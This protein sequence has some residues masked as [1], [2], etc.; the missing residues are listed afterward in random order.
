MEEGPGP[1]GEPGAAAFPEQE[2]PGDFSRQASSFQSY[3]SGPSRQSS[4][5]TMP[6]NTLLPTTSPR[7]LQSF[8]RMWPEQPSAQAMH[9]SSTAASSAGP[10]QP[11]ASPRLE[12]PHVGVRTLLA[13][14]AEL[15]AQLAPGWEEEAAVAAFK[16]LQR[17]VS[18]AVG[19]GS[20]EA[21]LQVDRAA[22]AELEEILEDLGPKE[23]IMRFVVTFHQRKKMYRRQTA[24]VF[25][26]LLQ[27]DA[28]L[29]ALLDN[30]ALCSS[31]P[32]DLQQCVPSR[33]PVKP[34]EQSRQRSERTVAIADAVF[35]ARDVQQ[36]RPGMQRPSKV[37]EELARSLQRLKFSAVEDRDEAACAFEELCAAL[38]Q[39]LL[40][41]SEDMSSVGLEDFEPKGATLKFLA[42]FYKH[43]RKYRSRVAR[44][45][46]QL[47]GFEGWQQASEAD[48]E[49][50][51]H[52]EEII[53]GQLSQSPASS[54]VATPS[55]AVTPKP[56]PGK[57]PVPPLPQVQAFPSIG[58]K[59]SGTRSVQQERLAAAAGAAEV[60]LK[61]V[62]RDAPWYLRMFFPIFG[63]V[64]TL[65]KCRCLV[66]R[67][68][69]QRAEPLLGTPLCVR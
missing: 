34:T 33:T 54:T 2:T 9:G 40:A 17:A 22:E 46:S 43:R 14:S 3:S 39:A 69:Q 44:A 62:Q 59:A 16:A 56:E 37:L 41:R 38:K 66:P 51:R 5:G 42:S 28:W 63:V 1:E 12:M 10:A 45:L 57:V 11:T 52:C 20:R 21:L 55:P 19:S 8:I 61:D 30:V 26:A 29:W 13:E 53:V 15:I 49:L 24:S 6:S 4:C 58:Q 7:T 64:G 67:A 68:L 60:A 27:V 65:R 18:R 23:R 48:P 25:S 35:A 47:L 32:L 36:V 31:L 50:H